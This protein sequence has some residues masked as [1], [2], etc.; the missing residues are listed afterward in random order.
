MKTDQQGLARQFDVQTGIL[1]NNGLGSTVVRLEYRD[2][3]YK[4]KTVMTQFY[5]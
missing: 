3:H 4:D 5:L 2:S 1:Y